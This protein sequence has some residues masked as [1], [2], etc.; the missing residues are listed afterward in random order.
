MK[1][2]TSVW[3]KLL[4]LIDQANHLIK[5][6]DWFDEDKR[7]F[8]NQKDEFLEFIIKKRPAG[9]EIK[10]HYIPYLKYSNITKD[11]AGKLMRADID[12][13]P[14]EYYLSM[15]EPCSQDIELPE[16]ATI[17]IEINCEKRVFCFHIPQYKTT[18][19]NLDI[20]TLPK[21]VWI[22]GKEF[23]RKQLITIS[24]EI[25]HLKDQIINNA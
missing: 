4:T 22:S 17:E 25:G 20:N 9:I 6:G 21:K 15:V 3:F 19:W 2:L 11:K 13:K 5:Q 12:K 18:E 23:H 10:F 16:K 8:Y 14:F 24:N 1:D 7:Y